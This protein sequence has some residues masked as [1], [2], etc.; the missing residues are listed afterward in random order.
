MPI[1]FVNTVKRIGGGAAASGIGPGTPEPH[2]ISERP[3][4]ASA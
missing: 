1:F 3:F 2:G 4:L